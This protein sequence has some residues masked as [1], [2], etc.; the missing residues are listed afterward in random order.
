MKRKKSLKASCI[1]QSD[2][3]RITILRSDRKIDISIEYRKKDVGMMFPKRQCGSNG[4][5][6]RDSRQPVLMLC[7]IYTYFIKSFANHFGPR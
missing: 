7:Q 1:G 3:K 2:R 4:R 6:E 5:R